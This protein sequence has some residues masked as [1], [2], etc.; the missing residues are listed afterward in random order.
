M[1]EHSNVYVAIEAPLHQWNLEPQN[2][3]VKGSLLEVV[4]HLE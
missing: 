2:P 4:H 1:V 3:S